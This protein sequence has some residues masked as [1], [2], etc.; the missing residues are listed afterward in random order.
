MKLLLKAIASDEGK[1]IPF[2]KNAAKLDDSDRTIERYMQ[3]LREAD[4]IEFR[5]E[6]SQTGG[7]FVKDS[8]KQLLESEKM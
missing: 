1:R 4:L 6:A 5:G 8:I 2:Y 3:Q 7:Y